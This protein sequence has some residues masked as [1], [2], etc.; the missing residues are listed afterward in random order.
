MAGP[1]LVAAVIQQ[2]GKIPKIQKAFRIVPSGKQPG[3]RAIKLRG[4]VLIDPNDDSVDLFTKIIEERKRNKDDA[5]L[6]YGLKILANSIY[7]FFVELIPEH[8]K[9][10]KSVMVFSGDESFP[11]SAGVIEKQGKWF[12]P[13]LATLITSA[14]RLLLAMLDVEVTRA[15]GAYLYCDTDSLAIVASEK[16]G[17]LRVPGAKGNRILT[18]SDVDRI[19]AKFQALNPYDPDAVPDLLNLTD[20]NYVCKCSH[21][22]KSE[23]DEPGVCMIRG[24]DCKARSKVRRQLWGIGVSAKRYSLF[25]KIVGR[26]GKLTGIKIV[27]PK[28]HGIGFLYP[29]KDNPKNWRRDAPLWIYEMWKYIVLGF[30]GLKRALPD[31][32]SLPQMMRF[33]VSTWNVL[34]IFWECGRAQGPTISCLW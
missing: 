18:W 7:G 5:G 2:P 22:L 23:H 26:N 6:Y 14:G 9:Q 19:T 17:P 16:G 3:M 21:E 32:A 31:W 12:A 13:Y 25:E 30:L 10:P 20:D 11:D 28:A 27:N 1:D 4:K 24:C 8:Y 33:S 34:K 29:P 15:G